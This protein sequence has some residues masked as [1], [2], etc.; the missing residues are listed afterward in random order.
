MPT[1]CTASR[2]QSVPTQVRV[3]VRAMEVSEKASL[4]YMADRVHF[5]SRVNNVVNFCEQ[6]EF[7]DCLVVGW[8]GYIDTRHAFARQVRLLDDWTMQWLFGQSA[9]VIGFGRTSARLSTSCTSFAVNVPCIQRKGEVR[10]TTTG[11][12]RDEKWPWRSVVRRDVWD[13]AFVFTSSCWFM[14]H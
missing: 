5:V 6:W 1:N 12:R 14:V 3:H 8:R 11:I 4:T 13:A 9:I 2:W 10:L 7:I